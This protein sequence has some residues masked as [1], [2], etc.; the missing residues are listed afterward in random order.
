MRKR[1]PRDSSRFS[2][3][4]SQFL[5]RRRRPIGG[6]SAEVTI[7]LKNVFMSQPDSRNSTASQSSNSGCDGSSPVTPKSPVVR[8]RPCR[9]LLPEAVDGDARRQ[10]LVGPQ[11]PFGEAEAVSAAN[12]P[13]SAARRCGVAGLHLVAALVVFAAIQHVGHRRFGALLS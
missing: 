2:G 5:R 11:Q 9:N 1:G 6:R 12:R 3:S 7:S 4:F 13:A 10:R 8:T